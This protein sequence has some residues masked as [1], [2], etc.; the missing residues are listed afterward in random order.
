MPYDPG[1]QRKAK[2]AAMVHALDQARR[3]SPDGNPSAEPRNWQH[4]AERLAAYT[5]KDWRLLSVAAGRP[6]RTP[7]ADTQAEVARTVATMA[8]A[9]RRAF[10]MTPAEERAV[11]DRLG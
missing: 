10:N 6:D 5:A 8:E 1:P 4:V 9:E 3:H 11:F 2:A 7:S